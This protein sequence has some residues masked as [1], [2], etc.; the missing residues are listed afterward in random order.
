MTQEMNFE[1][2]K[3]AKKDLL[4]LLKGLRYLDLQF[5]NFQYDTA[6]TP[7]KFSNTDLLVLARNTQVT[8]SR[9]NF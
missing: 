3:Q 9:E 8:I 2:I 7:V 1:G 6:I 5:L 4:S